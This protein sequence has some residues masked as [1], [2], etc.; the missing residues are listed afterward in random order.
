VDS[1]CSRQ[2]SVAGSREHGN[3]P[4]DLANGGDPFGESLTTYVIISFS[5]S[6][7]L[8]GVSRLLLLPLLLCAPR[9]N[10]PFSERRKTE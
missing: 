2:D 1:S 6:V 7:L 4:S 8:R 9:R 10:A 5:R 3:E